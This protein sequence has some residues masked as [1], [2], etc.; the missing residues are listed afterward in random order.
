MASSND[1]QPQFKNG[2]LVK[3]FAKR[4]NTGQHV[5]VSENGQVLK[6]LAIPQSETGQSLAIGVEA[7]SPAIWKVS[8]DGKLEKRILEIP[9][10]GQIK[11]ASISYRGDWL[12]LAMESTGANVGGN[13]VLLNLDNGRQVRLP[14]ENAK[15]LAG[16]RYI[17]FA[18]QDNDRMVVVEEI[19]G[20][21]NLRQ[22][23][24]V[25]EYKLQG[26]Q[27]IEVSRTAVRATGRGEGRAEYSANLRWVS[28]LSLIHIS[29][30]TRPY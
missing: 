21:E 6:L 3:H 23:V 26:Q 7:G 15:K 1:T 9:A 20:Y 10:L 25:V 12:G 8:V 24:Q 11:D 5:Q 19:K 17:Q 14:Q 16:C 13:V 29:E 4:L 2:W 28:G 22:R 27:L 30:P 18:D